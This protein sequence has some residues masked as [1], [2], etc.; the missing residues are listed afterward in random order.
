MKFRVSNLAPS[1]TEEMLNDLF[2]QYGDAFARIAVDRKSGVSR[3][4]GYVDMVDYYGLSPLDGKEVHGSAIEVKAVIW[5]DL[6]SSRPG[7]E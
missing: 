3:G 5:P 2:G 1:V 4:F 6:P 7:L